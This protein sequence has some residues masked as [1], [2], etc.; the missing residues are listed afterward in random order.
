MWSS[1]H[2]EAEPCAS[3][4]SEPQL[5]QAQEWEGDGP[6]DQGDWDQ[7]M[8]QGHD[9]QQR[10]LETASTVWQDAWGVSWPTAAWSLACLSCPCSCAAQGHLIHPVLPQSLDGASSVQPRAHAAAALQPAQAPAED[11]VEAL[12][13]P[14]PAVPMGDFEPM[15]PSVSWP[16]YDISGQDVSGVRTGALVHWCTGALVVNAA[17]RS[18]HCTKLLP[19][20]WMRWPV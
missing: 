2:A 17:A 1:P 15:L 16:D 20:T 10:S 4:S 11:P 12:P 9:L 18:A 6:A 8:S 19:L 14:L 5:D 13:A 7:L 3:E